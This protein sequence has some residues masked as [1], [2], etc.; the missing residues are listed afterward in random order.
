MTSSKKAHPGERDAAVAAAGPLG[1]LLVVVRHQLAAGRLHHLGLVGRRVV[2]MAPCVG[3]APITA[4]HLCT[5]R[6]AAPAKRKKRSTAVVAA[7][8]TC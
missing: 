8:D 2:G 3:N 1:G 4:N 7:A 5:G 6:P